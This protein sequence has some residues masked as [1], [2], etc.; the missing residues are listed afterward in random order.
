MGTIKKCDIDYL[1][2]NDPVICARYYRHT[3]RALKQLLLLD[4][5]FFGKIIDL[6]FVTEFQNRGSAHEH[7]LLWI[8]DAPIYQKNNNL[9]IENFLDKYIT[10][11]IDNLDQ[12]FLKMHQH[13]HTRICRKKKNSHCR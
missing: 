4:E 5:T 13:C 10:C 9:E 6:Y 8:E 11:N 1:V 12:N 7:G 2:R 3:I